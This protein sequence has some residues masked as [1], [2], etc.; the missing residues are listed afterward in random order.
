MHKALLCAFKFKNG[1]IKQI[2]NKSVLTKNNQRNVN[3][4][5]GENQKEKKK[6]KKKKELSHILLTSAST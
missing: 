6:K 3:S 4:Y 2:K 5:K 1:F